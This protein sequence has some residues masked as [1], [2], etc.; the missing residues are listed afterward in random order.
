MRVLAI[1]VLVVSMVTGLQ[2]N[3]FA[4]ISQAL[5]FSKIEEPGY[6]VV[7]EI[8]KAMEIR[9]YNASKWVGITVQSVLSDYNQKNS[10]NF[11]KLFGYIS[12]YSESL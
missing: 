3:M 8:G 2:A 9:D 12:K 11:M 1:S 10:G 6:T 4:G 7:E 5:G